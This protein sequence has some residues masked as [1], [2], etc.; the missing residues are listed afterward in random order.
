MVVIPKDP[1]VDGDVV[2][3]GGVYYAA[4]ERALVDMYASGGRMPDL[5]DQY[6]EAFEAA[7]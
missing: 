5:A 7:R 2:Q 4:P 3:V 1:D 6:A